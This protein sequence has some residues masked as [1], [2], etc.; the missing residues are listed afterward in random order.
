[1][2]NNYASISLLFTVLLMVNKSYGQDDF[3]VLEGPY[4]GQKPP[5]LTPELFAPGTIATRD[6]EGGAAFSNDMKEFYFTRQ[7]PETKSV[8]TVVF[9]SKDDRWYMSDVFPGYGPSFA[10]DGKVMHF[11]KRYKERTDSGWSEMKNLGSPFEEIRIMSLKVSNKGTYVFDEVGTNGDGIIRYSRLVDGIR[12]EPQPFGK[13]INTGLW[14]AHPYIAPDESYI[15]WDGEREGG[16][17]GSD[18]YVSFKEA[19][20]SWGEAINLGGEINTEVDDGGPRITPDGK[21]LFFSRVVAP[22]DGDRWPD[23]DTYWVDAQVVES[24]RPRN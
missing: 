21:Y 3:P 12:E 14:N 17:G 15:M 10:P 8:E 24:L 7:H 20:G 23:V 11:G 9:K 19:D 18:L 5:G 1:M 2:K 16:Y 13:E 4:L 22:A 6:W